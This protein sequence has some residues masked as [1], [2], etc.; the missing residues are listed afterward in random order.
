MPLVE[1]RSH[2]TVVLQQD[3]ATAQQP[4]SPLLHISGAEGATPRHRQVPSSSE[5]AL[6]LT[7]VSGKARVANV[8]VRARGLA[9]SCVRCCSGWLAENTDATI[10]CV[11]CH[12]LPAAGC[13]AASRSS[14][15][16]CA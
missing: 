2:H 4:A 8:R 15:S 16:G 1:A 11:L 12:S 3:L 13:F 6:P 10:C 9:S 5:H 7:E 14:L